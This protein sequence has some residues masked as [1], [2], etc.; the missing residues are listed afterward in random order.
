MLGLWL[1]RFAPD[2]DWRRTLRIAVPSWIAG[3]ALMGL[4]FFYF[5]SDFPFAAPYKTAVVMETSIE[6]CTTGVA[7]TTFAVFLL[8]RKI[9][10]RGWFYEKV[11]RPISEASYG[12][13]LMH[14]FILPVAS[15]HLKG[16]VS[17]PAAIAATAAVTFAV[18]AIVSLVVRR[19]PFVGRWLCG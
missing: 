18:S 11:V 8:F 5:V 9:D 19:I 4:P 14:M 16:A 7:L 10:F 6:Y 13:Y 17:T 15:G 2:L 1:R 3:A 12:M